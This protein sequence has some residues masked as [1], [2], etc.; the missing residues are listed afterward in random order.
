[1]RRLRS[2]AGGALLSQVAEKEQKWAQAEAG[3][4]GR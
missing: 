1:M 3:L 2:A 4:S